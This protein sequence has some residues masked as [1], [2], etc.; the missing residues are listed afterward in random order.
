[1]KASGNQWGPWYHW[2]STLSY[3][4]SRLSDVEIVDQGAWTFWWEILITIG[5][6]DC[7]R[8]ARSSVSRPSR[9]SLVYPVCLLSIPS[10]S[11]PFRPCLQDVPVS[12]SNINFSLFCFQIRKILRIVS[13]DPSMGYLRRSRLV[14]LIYLTPYSATMDCCFIDRR[15]LLKNQLDQIQITQ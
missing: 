10:I 8:V 12:V 13:K 11:R 5:L 7:L 6:G 15:V 4:T 2:T 14:Y 9:L 1:M 3:R